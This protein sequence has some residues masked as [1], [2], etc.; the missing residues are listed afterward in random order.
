[1]P[2]FGKWLSSGGGGDRTRVP[3][4]FQD[5]VYMCSR[6]FPIFARP[7]VQRQ[8]EGQTRWKLCLGPRVSNV[9]EAD[10]ELLSGFQNSPAKFLNRGRCYAA[11]A[12]VLS[13][14]IKSF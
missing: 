13:S 14:A 11:I 2:N 8:T 5:G 9:T 10:L 3:R 7:A 6:C 1:M 4:W 12:K